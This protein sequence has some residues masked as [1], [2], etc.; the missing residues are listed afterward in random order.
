[1]LV[2]FTI[3]EKVKREGGDTIFINP[4]HVIQVSL[5]VFES[6]ENDSGEKVVR[7]T[8]LRDKHIGIPVMGNIEEVAEKLNGITE[9]LSPEEALEAFKAQ[10]LHLTSE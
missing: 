3:H 9:N 7:I 1:M 10:G 2:E 6:W 5:E 8:N 4:R